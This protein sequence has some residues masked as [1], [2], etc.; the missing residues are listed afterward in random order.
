MRER[1]QGSV[2]EVPK[3]E[4]QPD[5]VL[6]RAHYS[7]ICGSDLHA[8][9]GHHVRRKLPL[10]PGHE[11]CG[12]VEAVGSRVTGLHAGSR[13]TVVAEQGCGNCYACNNGWTNV[14]TSKTL[15]GTLRWPGAFAEYFCAPVSHVIEL[16]DNMP[17]KLGALAEPTAV[18]VHATRQAAL[19]PGQNVLL[20][21]SGGIGCIILTVCKIRG[22]GRMVVCDVK[23]FNLHMAERQGATLTL[24]T[25]AESA[26]EQLA[27]HPDEPP[28]D[29]TFIAASYYD[30]LNQSFKLTQP[31]GVITLVGQFNK[32]GVIDIDKG[33]VKELKIASSAAYSRDDFEEGVRVLA[34]SPEAFL[35][36]VTQEIA[37][38]DV[39][40]TLGD[41]L[42]G[43]I[44]AVKILVRLS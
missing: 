28:A 33:R 43:R 2:I 7:G 10:I 17:L 11:T 37:L 12:I 42:A 26:P 32:P 8:Y 24:N 20:F 36:I 4:P 15:L 19:Q 16:P 18:A 1:L 22:A 30:L 41:M 3:P 25:A 38:D 35:P 34:A 39:D 44:N 23:D 40:S 9:E 29:A 14:C 13:V 31:H 6:I 27:H 5:E 21:G